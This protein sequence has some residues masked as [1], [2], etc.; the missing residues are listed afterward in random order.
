MNPAVQAADFALIRLMT[1]LLYCLLLAVPLIAAGP[2]TVEGVAFNRLTKAGAPGVTVGLAAVADRTKAIY[3]VKS[4]AGGAF[5]IGDVPEGDYV[6]LVD[7]PEGFLPPHNLRPF[8]VGEHGAKVDVPLAP[9]GS[10]SGR[11]LD[12]QGRPVPRMRVE[13]FRTYGASAHVLTTDAEGRFSQKNIVPGLYNLRARPVLA[14]SILGRK[15]GDLTPLPGTP[16]EGER[17]MWAPTYFPNTTEIGSAENIFVREGSDLAGLDI[18][19]R[20]API[21][22][23]RGVVED[24]EGKPAPGVSL[25]LLSEIGWGP[26]EVEVKSGAEGVFEFPSVRA[27]D[28][29]I[30]ASLNRDNIKWMGRA[31]LTMPSRDYDKARVRIEPPFE[32]TGTIEGGPPIDDARIAVMLDRADL[33]EGDTLLATREREG[34]LR[35]KDVYPG[36]YR[37]DA[38]VHVPGHYLK[39]V[40]LGPKDVT[41]QDVDL[42]A[43]SPAV[44]LVLAPNAAQASG[45]VDNGAGAK[46]VFVDTDQEVFVPG[47]AIKVAIC[48]DQG[49]F[50]IEGLRPGS[51]HAFAFDTSDNMNTGAIRDLVFKRGL[52]QQAEVIH[53]REGETANLKLQ[54]SRWFE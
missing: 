51:W 16:P 41:G 49:R 10:V 43:A 25:L 3:T 35:I 18:R 8:H 15:P 21:H 24:N 19:L 30:E 12:L 4:E 27:G 7:W 50:T 44:R 31:V 1:R 2:G 5:R 13:L 28:W 6:L 53:L 29:R 52:A 11:V 9:T 38:W 22:Q 23:L 34:R 42:T 48:D 54:I 32:L 40:L 14:G 39:S 36:R 20:A 46:V 17:W 47:E 37:V 33:P 26:A 45:T